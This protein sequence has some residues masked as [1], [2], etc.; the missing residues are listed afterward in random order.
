M[1]ARSRRWLLPAVLVIVWLAVGGPL[2][3]FQG[4]LAGVQ[5]N[6][7][8]A[9]LPSEAESTQVIELQR[10][11]TDEE[12]LPAIVVYERL[13]GLS[14]GDQAA[15]AED[16]AE[17]AELD[18]VLGEVSP[19]IPSEDGQAL[20]VIVPIDANLGDEIAAVVEE[21]RGIAG[22]GELD[23]FVTGPAGILGDFVVAFG[24]IDGLLLLVTAA[25]VALI[26]ILVYRSPLLPVIVL[27]AVALALGTA[28]AVVYALTSAGVIT[29][30]GQSQGI[31]LV[32]VFGAATDYALLLISR[33][34]EELRRQENKYDAVR[35]ALR[36]TALPI[37]AS[38][39]TVIVGVLCLLFS[40]LNS[41]RGLG[42]VAAIGIASSM[43][44]QLTFLPAALALFGRA[45]F[46]PIR[47]K[48][49]SDAGD[50]G[51]WG[52][53]SG[54]VGRRPRAVWVSSA[55][56]LVVAAAFATQLNTSGIEQTDVFL[57]EV[58][59]VAGQEALARHFPAGTGSPAVIVG[60]ADVV[61]E[62]VGAVQGVDG[63]GV[64]TALGESPAGPPGAPPRVVDGLVQLN[65]VL[66]EPADSRAAVETVRELR[67]V[68]DDVP[69]AAA[70]V[71]GFTAT[72][73]DTQDA[74]ARDQSVIIPIITIVIFLILALLLR[75]LV[76][77][78]VLIATVVL[79]FLATLGVSALVFEEI[80]G[81]PGSDPGVV[82]F[83][84]IFLVALGID[85]NIFLMTRVREEAQQV[86][87]RQG[88]LTGLRVTGGV[89]TS[90]GVVLAATFSALGVLPLLFLAQIA[91]IVAFGV[92]LDATIVRSLLVPALTL[93]IGEKVWWPSRLALRRE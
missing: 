72:Q 9:F 24:S 18:G 90:A 77:P 17:F 8:A 43:L 68:V 69:G 45:A 75:A 27:V 33:Y 79:S 30:N 54:L 59:S 81:F 63:V 15:V 36:A 41:N 93:E 26:L 61:D 85:Y 32:L 91:F 42:P 66:D 67:E 34:R 50:H 2:G 82:L 16:V 29:L 28:S 80:F 83:G 73:L 1:P 62:L 65:A 3:S 70:L 37:L 87:T 5:E 4:Q 84:F 48:Y 52:R 11:F 88:V 13:D 21:V 7:N 38:G 44:V 55:A 51:I 56:V 6:D 47:P 49:G 89:I 22:S 64:V 20:Q 10:K 23:S 46:W 35:V 39:G 86:G 74:A 78:V 25:V 92:L 19:P 76:A 60:N 31:L 12:V 40:E 14:Q 57:T 58:P 53:V 71:G